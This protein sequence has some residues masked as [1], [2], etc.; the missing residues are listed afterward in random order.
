MMMMVTQMMVMMNWRNNQLVYTICLAVNLCLLRNTWRATA[1]CLSA[2]L[3]D[4][5]HFSDLYG[6]L[7]SRGFLQ[8]NTHNTLKRKWDDTWTLGEEEGDTFRELVGG[9]GGCDQYI[10]YTCLE[11]LNNRQ[12]EKGSVRSLV[13]CW[14]QTVYTQSDLIFSSDLVLTLS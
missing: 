1:V 3:G 4:Q 2:T 13:I 12:K 10:L 11:F 8:A 14:T 5:K 9:N 6:L 7:T